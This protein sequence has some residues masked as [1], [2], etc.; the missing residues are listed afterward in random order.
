MRL[1]IMAAFA[2][3]MMAASAAA[4]P[5]PPPGGGGFPEPNP[6][7]Q[8]PPSQFPPQQNPPGP[9]TQTPGSLIGL[10]S[11]SLHH[12]GT[13]WWSFEPNGTTQQ[14][15]IL[16]GGVVDYFGQYQVLAGGAQLQYVFRDYAPRT[17]YPMTQLNQPM[18]IDLQWVSPNLF[19]ISDASGPLR[20]VRQR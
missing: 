16:R 18:T 13:I 19:F 10:W 11:T 12:G 15:Y 2:V 7:Q 1:T 9:Q 17:G 3:A 4:Q 20:F 8:F 6:P 5:L 14:R